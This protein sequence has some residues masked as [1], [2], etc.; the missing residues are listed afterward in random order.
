[1]LRSKLIFIAIL[2]LLNGVFYLP[3]LGNAPLDDYD[4]ATYAQVVKEMLTNGNWLTFTYFDEVWIDKPPLQFWLMALSS[5]LFGLNEFA[6]RLPTA[7]FGLAASLFAFGIV[8]RINGNNSLALLA[9]AGVVLSPLFLSAGRDIRLEIPVA[10]AALSGFY[11]FIRGLNNSKLLAG[12]GISIGLGIMIKSVFGLLALVPIAMWSLISRNWLWLKR[13]HFW[14]G[15]LL[16]ALI[17]LPWHLYEALKLGSDFLQTYLGF[18]VVQRLT[19]NIFNNQ[20]SNWRYLSILF[21]YG[22]PW[23]LLFLLS[24]A[25]VVVAIL[26]KNF[27]TKITKSL[28]P[29]SSLTIAVAIILAGFIL[30]PSKLMTYLLPLFPFMV[31]AGVLAIQSLR[32]ALTPGSKVP[33]ILAATVLI[34]GGVLSFNEVFRNSQFF[35]L[36][37]SKDEKAIGLY[38]AENSDQEKV[39]ILGWPHHQTLRYYSGKELEILQ[40]DSEIAIPR[41]FWLIVPNQLVEKYPPL[42]NLPR[43]Y[44]GK[45]LTLA[46]F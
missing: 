10:A 4:E 30:I 29:I 36:D 35:T 34:A 37:F 22:L 44:E 5:K 19:D 23:S 38:A 17:V 26:N 41:P 32:E 27:R 16:G 11:F 40:G 21:K 20:L 2:I 6:L 9:G 14:I 12:V 42:K 31:I 46:H 18:H 13:G 28:L 1:M 45:Y 8:K 24:M 7:L 25:I 43:L 33:V 15:A 39:Y 3:K